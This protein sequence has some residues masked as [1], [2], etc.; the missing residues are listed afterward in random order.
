MPILCTLWPCP[1]LGKLQKSHS[2]MCSKRYVGSNLVHESL[3]N[4]ST[5]G[6]VWSGL[7]LINCRLCWHVALRSC[8]VLN[9]LG[10]IYIVKSITPG[11]TYIDSRFWCIRTLLNITDC[12]RTFTFWLFCFHPLFQSTE[13][14]VQQQI[15]QQLQRF[16][17]HCNR[18]YV[19]PNTIHAN[20]PNASNMGSKSQCLLCFNHYFP[21]SLWYVSLHVMCEWKLLY[22]HRNH[23]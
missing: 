4:Y 5:W 19:K 20:V 6:L 8:Q 17:G 7:K 13:H 22:I 14:K 12:N 1:L 18:I 21:T 9:V 11:L 3:T 2:S 15:N 10:D 16:V 23:C